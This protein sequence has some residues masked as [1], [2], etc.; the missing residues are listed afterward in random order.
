MWP[1][2]TFRGRF[3]AATAVIAFLMFSSPVLIGLLQKA[4]FDALTHH[5]RAR[6][7]IWELLALMVALAFSSYFLNLVRWLADTHFRFGAIALLRR[8]M[9]AHVLGRPGADA[10]P[11]SPGE[12]MTRFRDDVAGV[13]ELLWLPVMMFGQLVAGVIAFVILL[14]ISVVITIAVFLPL[15]GIIG[16]TQV[17]A[18]RLQTFRRA[19]RQAT[20]GITGFLGEL[21]GAVQAVKVAGAEERV[22]DRFD[23]LNEERRRSMV[24]DQTFEQGMW[25]IYNNATQLGTGVMLLLAAAA[26]RSDRFTVGDFALFVSY[27]DWL[28]GLPFQFGRLL[29]RYKQARISFERMTAL[30]PGAPPENLVRHGDI[31]LDGRLPHVPFHARNAADRLREVTVRQLTY[32]YPG[33]ERGIQNVSLD[34]IRGQLVVV[35]GRIGAGKSTLLRVLLGLLPRDSGEIRWNGVLVDDPAAFFVPPH[36][37]YTAQVPRLFSD[38]LRDNILL[39]LPEDRVDLQR[40][41]RLAVL[42]ED[43]QTLEAGL[44]TIVGPRGV[45]LSGGQIQRTAAARMFV[46]DAEL[47]VL[48]DLSSA[49]DVETEASLWQ[50]IFNRRD[51][52]VLAVSH[53]RP[54]LRRAD[55]IVVMKDGRVEALGPLDD[56]LTRSRE[57]QHLWMSHEVLT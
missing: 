32:R 18:N 55:L 9:L 6:F 7:G 35:T 56:L 1:L 52:T 34:I 53:R 12:A 14:R 24:R 31:Y 37:A 51:A 54:A 22:L 40:A 47:L 39:G 3:Y 13:L 57:M 23:S 38:S 28:S 30:L 49:L 19:S 48:D 8:N 20:G 27:L 17:V 42:E 26:M 11:S 21:F 15:A 44:D 16:V 2:V 41:V 29:S 10:L 43:V 33:V 36:A 5:T 46:R 50:R 45:R 4:V 25:A